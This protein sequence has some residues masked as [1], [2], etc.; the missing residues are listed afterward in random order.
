MENKSDIDTYTIANLEDLLDKIQYEVWLK[1]KNG[2]YIYINKLGSEKLGLSKEEIIGKTDYEI[3]PYPIANECFKTDMLLMTNPN[4]EL[5]NNEETI[6][7]NQ[8][9]CYKVRKFSLNDKNENI[10]LGGMAEE[11]SLE[12]SI[13]NE[14]ERIMTIEKY[15][16][17]LKMYYLNFLVKKLNS[18][19]VILNSLNI[20]IFLYNEKYTTLNLYMSADEKNS[21][22]NKNSKLIIDKEIK[23]FL[24]SE[25]IY[26]NSN[27]KLYSKIM[28]IKNN[29]YM[30]NY[31]SKF[32]NLKIA[33]NAFSL[34]HVQYENKNAIRYKDNLSISYIFKKICLLIYQIEKNNAVLSNLKQE[35]D[36]LQ[37]AIDFEYTKSSF[38]ANISHEFR[39][40]VNIILSIIQLL[41][42]D[43]GSEFNNIHKEKY[44]NYLNILKQ[45]S[46]R[47]LRLVN[48]VVDT[49]KVDTNFYELD[50]RK[51][52]IVKIIE[53]IT[54]STV[55]FIESKNKTIVFDTNSEEIIL[56]CDP[57]KI[58]RILLNLISNAIKFSFANSEIRVTIFLN[59]KEQRVYISVIN[60]GNKIT[61]CESKKIFE[62]FAQSDNLF[63]RK[64]E[65]SGIG[66]F[67]SKYFTEM[68]E[69]EIWLNLENKEAVEFRFYLPLNI[70]TT[71][72]AKDLDNQNDAFLKNKLIEQCNVEFSDI[73]DI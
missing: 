54:M 60:D 43:T 49:A 4:L 41:E 3:R 50:L 15:S 56:L 46:Y 6:N 7:D 57:D 66:L 69:G 9:I 27:S 32:Y 68:H 19:N 40:P 36:S 8:D 25:T 22:F 10:I 24:E 18:L 44:I 62:Q 29:K 61:E 20:D 39:T 53:D 13:Q 48:N 72:T 58:E 65:G 45:N 34:I 12:K 1:N 67:L 55:K 63:I 37:G 14:I 42:R 31:I 59:E 70:K 38:F 17:N 21:M 51:Y 35:K 71:T 30:D 23:N 5:Y 52:N 64:T 28:E 26:Y 11:I 2:K 73:Y 16:P 33:D 47:L